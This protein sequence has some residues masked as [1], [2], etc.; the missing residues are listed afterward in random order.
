MQTVE[1]EYAKTIHEQ[2]TYLAEAGSHVEKK[3]MTSGPRL[4]LR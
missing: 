4:W 1:C 2:R 3:N